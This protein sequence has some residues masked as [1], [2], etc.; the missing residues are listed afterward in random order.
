MNK[1]ENQIMSDIYMFYNN[2]PLNI[3]ISLA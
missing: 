1:R 2:L 3:Y